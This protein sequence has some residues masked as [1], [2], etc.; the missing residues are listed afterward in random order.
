MKKLHDRIERGAESG[1]RQDDN[2]NTMTDAPLPGGDATPLWNTP[3]ELDI[4]AREGTDQ[5]NFGFLIGEV[6]R[7]FAA[8]TLARQQV[9]RLEQELEA[10]RTNHIDANVRHMRADERAESAE[11]QVT[12]LQRRLVSQDAFIDK[13]KARAEAAEQQHKSALDALRE[14]ANG[15]PTKHGLTDQQYATEYLEIVGRKSK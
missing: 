5:E 9:T 2:G 12:A 8:L 14:I 4:I 15:F 11:A 13:Y 3:E 6:E 1:M 7:L 10:S